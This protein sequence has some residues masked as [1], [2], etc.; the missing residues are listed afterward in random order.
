MLKNCVRALTPVKI[1][2]SIKKL[3]ADK[4]LKEWRLKGCPVPPPHIVKQHAIREYQNRYNCRIFIETGTYLGEMIEAQKKH[5]NKIYSIEL[6]PKL[7]KEA[8]RRFRNYSNVTILFGDSGKVLPEI[9][10][11]VD[12]GVIFWLDGHYSAGVTAKGE[13]ECPVLEELD[14]IFSSRMN[15]II[16]IDDARFF[17]GSGDFPSIG[18][19]EAFVKKRSDSYHFSIENDIITLIPFQYNWK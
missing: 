15:H 19:L 5:F 2:W 4:Q 8:A 18:E 7:Y 16:L 6:S 17:T 1:R 9:L 3:F 11:D 10:K 14:A 13:K 12:E